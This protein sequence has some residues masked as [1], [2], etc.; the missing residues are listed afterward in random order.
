MQVTGEGA[1]EL[2]FLRFLESGGSA[3]WGGHGVVHYHDMLSVKDVLTINT[4]S[5]TATTEMQVKWFSLRRS[6]MFIDSRHD[7]KAAPFGEAE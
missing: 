5:A 3:A 7:Q 4:R 1:K 2:A 6:A